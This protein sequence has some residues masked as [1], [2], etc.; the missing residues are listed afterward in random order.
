MKGRPRR[1]GVAVTVGLI[2][3]GDAEYEA[4]PRLHRKHLVARCPPL[5]ATNLG[6]VGSTM[7]PIAIARMIVS[8]I[9]AHQ[10]AGRNRVVVCID[11]EQRPNCAPSFAR[12]VMAATSRELEQRGKSAGEVHVIVAD[13]TFEAWLLA[14]AAGLHATGKLAH[15]P[16]FHCFEG[17]LGEANDKGC[18]ELSR[19]LGRPYEKTRDGP[20]LFEALDFGQARAHRHGGRGSRSL[21]KLLRTLGV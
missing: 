11:R 4:L 16:S 21:D 14:G 19:L 8:K 6:G 7:Q 5:K 12:E 2:V 20:A 9:I 10:L 15:A 17:E 18:R 13:R 1:A 3:E